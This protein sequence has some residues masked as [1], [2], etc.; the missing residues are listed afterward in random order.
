LV[1]KRKADD[2]PNA[3]ITGAIAVADGKAF[4]P[5]QGLG[6]ETSAGRGDNKCC[7]FRGN[8]TALDVNTGALLWKTYTVDE[9]KP[10][11]KNARNGTDAFGPR[12]AASGRRR[13]LIW[14]AAPSTSRPA[15][16]TPIRL[17]P[18]TD[19]VVAVDM[20]SGKVK[21]FYPGHEGRQL[22]GRMPEKSDG[23]GCPGSVGPD[24]DF[25]AAP[26]LATIDGRS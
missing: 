21:W 19:S 18:M 12:A 14:L 5:I 23:S 13:P 20:Q 26:M 24:H 25:S 10:R 8:L 4:V 7:T 2:H 17:Q 1:W 9:P 6:E 22:A 16:A 15:T 3:A 11:G